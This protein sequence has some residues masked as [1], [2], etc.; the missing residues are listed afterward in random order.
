[1]DKHLRIL[2]NRLEKILDWS[3]SEIDGILVAIRDAALTQDHAQLEDI[4]VVSPAT[5][6]AYCFLLLLT[7]ICFPRSKNPLACQSITGRPASP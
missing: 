1:M 3:A 7:S 4:I 6:L 5:L 2:A